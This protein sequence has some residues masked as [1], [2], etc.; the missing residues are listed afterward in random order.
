MTTTVIPRF[1]YKNMQQN[2]FVICKDESFAFSKLL[3]SREEQVYTGRLIN[4]LD[5]FSHD[6]SVTAIKEKGS[7]A[8]AVMISGRKGKYP[9]ISVLR[10]DVVQTEKRL[11]VAELFCHVFDSPD[12]LKERFHFCKEYD[13]DMQGSIYFVVGGF[14]QV[15]ILKFDQTETEPKLE[16]HKEVILSPEKCKVTCFQHFKHINLFVS[17]IRSADSRVEKMYDISTYQFGI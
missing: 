2:I 15:F 1:C 7:D 16:V 12:F 17:E 13:L 8:F 4:Y 6:Y 14:E 11:D 10:V 9:A 5:H 3:L